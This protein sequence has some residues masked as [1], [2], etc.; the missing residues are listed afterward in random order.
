[1]LVL[2]TGQVLIGENGGNLL[3]YNPDGVPQDNWRPVIQG[4]ITNNKNGRS[5]SP[6]SSS[7]ALAKDRATET[8]FER[9]QLS[10]SADG[11]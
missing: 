9:Q 5:R 4:T 11:G 2:P 1:M 10:D 7:T 6:A 3:V 8:I